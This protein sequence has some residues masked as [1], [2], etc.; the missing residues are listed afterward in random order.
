MN[1]TKYENLCV[2]TGASHALGMG[3]CTK[4]IWRRRRAASHL[5]VKSPP[6]I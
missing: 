2:M 3:S 6:D 5:H 1:D 4:A